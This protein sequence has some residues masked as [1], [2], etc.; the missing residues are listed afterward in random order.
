MTFSNA[1]PLPYV[2]KRL[3]EVIPPYPL[4]NYVSAHTLLVVTFPAVMQ[5]I[6]KKFISVCCS[7]FKTKLKSF[8]MDYLHKHI[9]I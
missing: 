3:Q 6:F 2:Q 9:G 5:Y 8:M 4:N 1:W 7:H